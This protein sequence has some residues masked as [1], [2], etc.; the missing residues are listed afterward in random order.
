MIERVADL[1][2]E[3]VVGKFYLVPCVPTECGWVPVIGPR[4]E[5]AEYIG[6]TEWH[7]HR[8]A[9]FTTDAQN[10]FTMPASIL[11]PAPDAYSLIAVVCRTEPPT[12]KKRKCRR[13]MPDFPNLIRRRVT[14][15]FPATA[16]WMKKLEEAY[17][18]QSAKCGRCPHRGMPLNG[19]PVKDG[20]IICNGHGLKWNVET[21]EAVRRQEVH[22]YLSAD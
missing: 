1:K 18:G 15:L 2:A 21:G 14:P 20:A 17:A 10:A 3:P 6:F 7:Y 5:D 19:L 4:H 11:E 12:E 9:R 16:P 8:D 22:G 13:R